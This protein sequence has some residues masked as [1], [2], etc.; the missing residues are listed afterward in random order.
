MKKGTRSFTHIADVVNDIFATSA[1]PINLGDARIWKLW[2]GLVGEEIARHARPATINKGVLF[3][4]VTDSVWLQELEFMA[5]EIKTRI[6][7]KL[8]REAVRKIRFRVGAPQQSPEPETHK[9]TRDSDPD[10]SPE[11]EREMNKILARV[12]DKELRSSIRQLL[13][14]AVKKDTVR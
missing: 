8:K 6:N 3:V 1:L 11:T 14:Q 4:K 5:E 9:P 2:D 13:K 12:K 7:E 10:L